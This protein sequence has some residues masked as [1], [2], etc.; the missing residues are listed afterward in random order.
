MD[1]PLVGSSQETADAQAVSLV[2]DTEDAADYVPLLN[3]FSKRVFFLGEVGQGHKT[4]LVV[5][6]VLGLN[7]LVLAEGLGLAR[8]CGMDAAQVLEI[9]KSSAAYSEV[10]DTQ[11]GLMLSQQFSHPAARLAQHAKDVLLILKL[12]QNVDARVPLSNLHER[13]LKEAIDSNWGELDNSAVINLFFYN[14]FAPSRSPEKGF[15]K[16]LA[17]ISRR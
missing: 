12:A 6:L 2:G 3:T 8:R 16:K 10:M 11:G 9:L 14:Y 1:C 15:C 17:W 5:N 7:R 4:K 13:L